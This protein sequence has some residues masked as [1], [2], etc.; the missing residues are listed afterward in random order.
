MKVRFAG[1]TGAAI[2]LTWR[3]AIFD[4]GSEGTIEHGPLRGLEGVLTRIANQHRM[5]V[6]VT[7]L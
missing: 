2:A 5:F 1:D 3:P 7:L 6:S 4:G